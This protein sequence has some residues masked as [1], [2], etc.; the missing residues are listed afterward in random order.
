M[1]KRPNLRTVSISIVALTVP[2]T[3]LASTLTGAYMKA[4]NPDNVDISQGF[5][6]LQQT[7]FAGIIVFSL[8]VAIVIGLISLLYKQDRHFGNAKLPLVLL[9]TV[10][11]IMGA[12]LLG[13]AYTN[14][15][16]DNY[17]IKNNRP[18]ESQFFEALDRQKQDANK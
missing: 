6:Y 10:V 14:Q 3:I 12:T 2:L 11:V 16:R 9:V 13:N 4:N 1:N 7:L 17:L 15:V 8:C 18:T 5:A